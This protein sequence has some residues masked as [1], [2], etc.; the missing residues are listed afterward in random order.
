MNGQ[1]KVHQ[2]SPLQQCHDI[3][4]LILAPFR[5]CLALPLAKDNEVPQ[6]CLWVS[7]Y[8]TEPR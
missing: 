2:V 7:P 5:I 8:P 1:E 4:E 6:P 3:V